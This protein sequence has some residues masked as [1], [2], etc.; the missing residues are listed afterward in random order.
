[1]TKQINYS[2]FSNLHSI[3]SHFLNNP[4]DSIYKTLNRFKNDPE[5]G[6]LTSAMEDFVDRF[7]TINY[8]YRK[9]ARSL[10]QG[11][12]SIADIKTEA[13][14]LVFFKYFYEIDKNLKADQQYLQ[15]LLSRDIAH[16]RKAK[17]KEFQKR[18]QSFSFDIALKGKSRE[19]IF[20]VKYSLPSFFVNKLIESLGIHTASKEFEFLNQNKNKTMDFAR[21]R[22]NPE[23]SVSMRCD[24][25]SYGQDIRQYIKNIKDALSDS[26]NSDIKPDF[27]NKW[28]E[29]E[30][31]EWILQISK[32]NKT[33]ILK[34]A[35]F[36]EGK[37]VY[38]DFSSILAVL[39]LDLDPEDCHLI[40][41]MC[42]A[43]NIKSDLINQ[44]LMGQSK[45]IC[46][47]F[48]HARLRDSFLSDKVLLNIHFICQ[49]SSMP[50]IRNNVKFDKILLDAPCTGSGTFNS[51]PQAKLIQSAKFLNEMVTI[52]K[53]LIETIE[54]HSKMTTIV[55]YSVCSLY[56]EEGYLQINNYINSR[57][58]K[59]SLENLLP[60]IVDVLLPGENENKGPELDAK[61]PPIQKGLILPSLY[62]SNGFF[63]SKIKFVSGNNEP[64]TK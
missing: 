38:Q 37:I 9:T 57:Q 46:A 48:S 60:E 36:N 31:I 10:S 3:T 28:L 45:I 7:N 40:Y 16:H 55:V 6:S 34:S 18:I 43:P 62:G 22:L 47:D 1:M 25:E 51:N 63:I 27:L 49:D 23:R 8:I 35:P 59:K 52:Q 61:Q 14:L 39:C 42:S 53:A 56:D 64:N 26:I 32:S 12:E 24:T 29:F 5:F 17:M 15:F 58:D 50:A 2:F 33:D 20:S 4:N 11:K 41:D 21:I 13:F 19:E 54:S 44:I 30:N